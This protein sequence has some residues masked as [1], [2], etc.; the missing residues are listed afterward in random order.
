MKERR[1]KCER[2]KK[3]KRYN[4]VENDHSNR[5]GCFE[6]FEVK[7]KKEGESKQKKKKEKK[8]RD[9]VSKTRNE[10]EKRKKACIFQAQWHTKT[11]W[12]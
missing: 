9:S 3:K 4:R 2:R 11:R 1:F 7:K 6:E 10:V 8:K 12:N 5:C